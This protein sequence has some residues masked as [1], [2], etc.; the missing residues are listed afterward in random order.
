M[1]RINLK[2]VEVHLFPTFR[3]IYRIPVG[4]YMCC[5]GIADPNKWA[6]ILT[7]KFSIFRKSGPL[8]PFSLISNKRENNFILISSY[9]EHA[10]K[11]I[12]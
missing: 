2:A 5:S 7:F 6:T 12:Q 9:T 1:T 8:S 10:Q 3:K 11:N 4:R